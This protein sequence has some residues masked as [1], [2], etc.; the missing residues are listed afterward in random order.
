MYFLR[1]YIVYLS[2]NERFCFEN[3]SLNCR[4][5]N[6]SIPEFNYFSNPHLSM[7]MYHTIYFMHDLLYAQSTLPGTKAVALTKAVVLQLL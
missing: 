4:L 6:N 1:V 7:Y 5:G 3:K 2:H